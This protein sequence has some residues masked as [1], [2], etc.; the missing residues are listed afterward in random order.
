MHAF[1]RELSDELN[2]MDGKET[3]MRKKA[4]GKVLGL[5]M[6]AVIALSAAGCEREGARAQDLM[7]GFVD[8]ESGIP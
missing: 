8:G 2:N 5:G 4:C 7:K 1:H 3:D 6:V